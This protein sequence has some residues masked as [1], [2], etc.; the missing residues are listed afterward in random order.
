VHPDG[1]PLEQ[2]DQ[3]FERFEPRHAADIEHLFDE[4]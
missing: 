3:R 1:A 2:I 4:R